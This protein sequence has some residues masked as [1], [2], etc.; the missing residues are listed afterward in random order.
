MIQTVW[1]RTWLGLSVYQ[2]LSDMQ[3]T[4]L[5]LDVSSAGDIDSVDKGVITEVVDFGFNFTNDYDTALF[6]ARTSFL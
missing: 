5:C 4:S 3:I 6:V 2:K 1:S